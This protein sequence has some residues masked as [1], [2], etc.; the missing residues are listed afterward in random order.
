M[1]NNFKTNNS[2]NGALNVILGII[3]LIVLERIA[4]PCDNVK[5]RRTSDGRFAK[6]YLS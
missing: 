1:K 6:L 3:G 5:R 2:K 4:K